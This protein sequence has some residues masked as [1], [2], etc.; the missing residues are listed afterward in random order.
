MPLKHVAA[1]AQAPARRGGRLGSLCVR[2][3]SIDLTFIHSS[4]ACSGRQ[5]VRSATRP[6]TGDEPLVR[7][8]PSK[9]LSREAAAGGR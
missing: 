5:R 1:R 7:T 4:V 2:C 9:D 3:W 6:Q 8:C